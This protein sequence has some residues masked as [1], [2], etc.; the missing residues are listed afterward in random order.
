MGIFFARFRASQNRDNVGLHVLPHRAHRGVTEVRNSPY[1]IDALE[2]PYPPPTAKTSSPPFSRSPRSL[3]FFCVPRQNGSNHVASR[4]PTFVSMVPGERQRSRSGTSKP[5]NPLCAALCTKRLVSRTE[6]TPCMYFRKIASPNFR[7]PLFF[8][9]M[10][11]KLPRACRAVRRNLIRVNLPGLLHWASTHI[12]GVAFFAHWACPV[13][14][15]SACSRLP[16]L[17]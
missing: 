11:C 15:V 9:Y 4:N 17:C 3:H 1:P 14:G 2:H 5:K 8:F 10:A 6:S 7:R 12:D 16:W 13:S